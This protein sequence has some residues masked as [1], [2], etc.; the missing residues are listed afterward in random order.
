MVF[1]TFSGL[2]GHKAS[3]SALDPQLQGLGDDPHFQGPL[4]E[5]YL[6]DSD[7]DDLAGKLEMYIKKTAPLF[8]ERE[9][10]PIMKPTLIQAAELSQLKKVCVLLDLQP[11]N[12]NLFYLGCFAGTR[13]GVVGCYSHSCRLGAALEDICQSYSPTYINAFAGTAVG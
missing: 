4:H 2:Q 8:Y 7:A 9:T 13:F 3:V 11:F 1:M 10:S 5:I 12:V 6:L